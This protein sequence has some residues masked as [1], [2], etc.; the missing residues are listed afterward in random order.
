MTS[1]DGSQWK[2]SNALLHLFCKGRGVLN[3]RQNYRRVEILYLRTRTLSSLPSWPMCIPKQ[4][5]SMT[6]LVPY[7]LQLIPK[8]YYCRKTLKITMIVRN[9]TVCYSQM[10]AKAGLGVPYVGPTG[11]RWAW[12]TSLSFVPPGLLLLGRKRTER[13]RQGKNET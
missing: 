10:G 4:E 3:S 2:L 13:S 12:I 11:S 5:L 6:D 1:K 8:T 7:C 9:G